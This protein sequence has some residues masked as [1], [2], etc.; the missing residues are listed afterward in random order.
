MRAK[1]QTTMQIQ[2]QIGEEWREGPGF[3]AATDWWDEGQV[4]WLQKQ[5]RCVMT[6]NPGR[7]TPSQENLAEGESTENINKH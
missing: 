1:D 4:S 3:Y 2:Q 6:R 5:S 7:A